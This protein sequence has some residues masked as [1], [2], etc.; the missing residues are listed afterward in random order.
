MRSQAEYE[1]IDIDRNPY[2][3]KWRDAIAVPTVTATGVVNVTFLDKHLVRSGIPVLQG[4]APVAYTQETGIS[5]TV[6]ARREGVVLY[7]DLCRGRIAGC[8]ASPKHWHLWERIADLRAQGKE[9]RRGVPEASAA[10]L[11]LDSIYHPEVYRRRSLVAEG[12]LF[13]VGVDE[14]LDYAG[15]SGDEIVAELEAEPVE[16]KKGKR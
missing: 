14:V 1:S 4:L 16:P 7:E 12:G 2:E 6:H 8:E 3:N 11:G 5:L 10:R 13:A 9:P 15:F